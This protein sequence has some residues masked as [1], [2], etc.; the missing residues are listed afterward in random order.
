MKSGGIF[1]LL[2]QILVSAIVIGIAAF[3]TPG[4]SIAGGFGTLFIAAI[5]VG[6]LS[7]AAVR[8]LG[9]KASP[10]GAGLTGFLVSAAV[11]YLTR[12]IVDGFNISVIGA[13]LGALVL[14]IVDFII[15]GKRFR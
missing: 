1:A 3:F 2:I 5:V 11:L 13:L 8:F 4:F 15:P 9:V 6:V 12:Y 7:W 14:G 10:F